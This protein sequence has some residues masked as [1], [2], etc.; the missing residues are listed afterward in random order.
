M[1]IKTEKKIILFFIILSLIGIGECAYPLDKVTAEDNLSEITNV[2][3]KEKVNYIEHL[4]E[5][6]FKNGAFKNAWDV[7][8]K[9]LE[10]TSISNSYIEP[11]NGTT[12]EEFDKMKLIEAEYEEGNLGNDVILRM[13]T[14]ETDAPFAKEINDDPG[15]ANLALIFNKKILTYVGLSNNSFFFDS[16]SILDPSKVESVASK[17]FK[18]DEIGVETPIVLNLGISYVN[19]NPYMVI[20]MPSGTEDSIG[21]EYFAILDQKLDYITTKSLKDATE[22]GVIETYRA[23]D[24]YIV[25]YSDE[26]YKING[27][28]SQQEETVSE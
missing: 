15:T 14:F 2:E 9:I 26:F 5:P 16:Q 3:S 13:Y 27:P 20:S 17:P 1:I 22:N 8:L 18:Y 11:P 12:I 4:V 25:E 21:V 24:R 7:F 28:K 23:L 10:Q 19:N 6:S